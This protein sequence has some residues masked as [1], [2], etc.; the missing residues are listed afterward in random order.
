MTTPIEGYTV[1]T[2]PLISVTWKQLL[3]LWWLAVL[4]GLF[5][6]TLTAFVVLSSTQSLS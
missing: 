5:V 2:Y 6:A 3:A 1:P 4:G